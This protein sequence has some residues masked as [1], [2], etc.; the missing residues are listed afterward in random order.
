[1]ACC[2]FKT[3]Y[4][5]KTGNYVPYECEEKNV[6]NIQAS[7]LCIF[8]DEKYLT[9]PKNKESNEQHLKKKLAE[10]MDS[11]SGNE[12]LTCIGYHLPDFSYENRRI[13]KSVNFSETVFIGAS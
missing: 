8:H 3:S 2:Q 5:D 12:S 9:D 7:G 4:C 6:E 1:M 13:D 11:I 10:K